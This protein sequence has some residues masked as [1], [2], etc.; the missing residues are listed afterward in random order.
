MWYT[1]QINRKL[2]VEITGVPAPGLMNT[3]ADIIIMGP[4]LFKKVATVGG[5]KKNC[6]QNSIQV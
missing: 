2:L 5:L 3:G 4:E 1:L 6:R